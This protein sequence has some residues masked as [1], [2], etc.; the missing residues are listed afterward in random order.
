LVRTEP[1][2]TEL[3]DRTLA[4]IDPTEIAELTADLVRC[5]S[6]NPPPAGPS[7]PNT[8]EPRV[9][10][11]RAG[12]GQADA[13]E[14]GAGRREQWAD[15]REPGSGGHEPGAR[16]REAGSGPGGEGGGARID[17]DG[18]G[19]SGTGARDG[20]ETGVAAVLAAACEA[21]GLD[22]RVTEAAPGRPNL[23]ARLGPYGA[24]GLLLLA[25]TDTV[26][27]GDGWTVPA[28]GG[29]VSG[30][31][32]YGR[33]TSDMK[34]G[35]AASVVA[36][37]AL[38][39]AAAEAGTEL[40]L[41]VTLA[42][43]ADEEETGIG[44]RAFTA[45]PGEPY[46]AA[47]VPEPTEMQTIRACRGDC[48]VEVEVR[49]TAAHA[50]DPDTGANAIY[51]A[52]RIIEAVRA[53]HEDN[54]ARPHPLLGPRTWNVGLV[55]GGS[56]TAVVPDGCHVSIDRRLLPGETGA[57]AVAEIAGVLEALRLDGLGL[58]A[59]TWLGMEMP[60]FETPEDHPLVRTAHAAS[61]A[62]GAPARPIGGWTAACDGGFVARDL[63]VPAIVLG[64]GS[65]VDQAHRPDESVSIAELTVAA[66]TYALSALRLTG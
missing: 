29:T 14:R 21:R 42:A 18:A 2:R 48:Y 62:A 53:L 64:P 24:P 10:A 25:H 32:I 39:R 44:A 49:G 20:V 63:G 5:D 50:G 8:G 27:V 11:Y 15:G 30:G 17:G 38:R 52:A 46:A 1:V 45:T 3:E 58:T 55:Q 22:V 6:Q 12:A 43:V 33:G 59:R 28:L 40:P 65:V 7:E 16:G 26:P 37:A 47:I 41:P 61:V 13:R 66:R 35:I 31:R 51:G 60:G 4:L 9:D 23:T 57:H 54:R 19:S 56:G 34:G 36:M